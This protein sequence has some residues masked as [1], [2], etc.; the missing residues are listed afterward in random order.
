MTSLPPGFQA[1][2]LPEGFVVDQPPEPDHA[3]ANASLASNVA[4]LTESRG[5]KAMNKAAPIEAALTIGSGMVLGFPAYLGGGLGTLAARSMGIGDPDQD[6]QEVAKRYADAVTYHPFSEKGKRLAETLLSPLTLLNEKAEQAG[7]GVTDLT[8]SPTAGALTEATIQMLPA[9][10]IGALGRRLSGKTPTNE[11]IRDTAT[12]MTGTAETAPV[13]HVAAKLQAVYEKTGLDPEIVFQE[14]QSDPTILQ[15]LASSNIEV[16]KTFKDILSKKN[17]QETIL[18]DRLSNMTGEEIESEYQGIK[19]HNDIVERQAIGRFLG[20]DKLSEFDSLKT[21]RAQDRW[22]DENI[23]DEAQDFMNENM[24]PEAFAEQYRGAAGAF[25]ETSPQTLGASIAVLSKDI[26]KPGFLSSPSGT[27]FKAAL[28]YAH[29]R[30]WDM[31]EVLDAM[32]KRAVQWAGNDAK[33]LFSRIFKDATQTRARML[34]SPASEL[35]GVRADLANSAGF[36]EGPK[37]MDVEFTDTVPSKT[38]QAKALL[39]EGRRWYASGSAKDMLEQGKAGVA[40][41]KTPEAALGEAMPPPPPEKPAAA[42]AADEWR[43]EAE[44]TILS[45]IVQ[46]SE[47]FHVTLKNLFIDPRRTLSKLYTEGVDRLNPINIDEKSAGGRAKFEEGIGPYEAQRLTAGVFGKASLFLQ[48]GPRKFGDWTKK[49][50]PSIFDVLDYVKDDPRGFEAYIVSKHA[51][52]VEARGMKSGFD[53]EAAKQ[54]VADGAE[55]FEKPMQEWNKYGDAVLDYLKDAGLLSEGSVA[56]MRDAYKSHVPF[57]R[58]FEEQSRPLTGQPRNPIKKMK[59]SERDT[60]DP[61]VSKI[62]DTFLFL[63]LA[64]KNAARQKMVQLGPEFA[65]PVEMTARPEPTGG[66]LEKFMEDGD[67]E[68]APEQLSAFKPSS[69]QTG[70]DQIVVFENGIRKL[71]DVN[72]EVARAFNATDA[73]SASILASMLRASASLLRAG[74]TLAPEF[75]PRNMTRDA[76]SAF[77]YVGAH[78]IKTVKGAISLWTKDE[79]FQRWMAGGGANA[80]IV[81]MDRA[82]INKEIFSLNEKTGFMSGVWNT[83]KTPIE[84]LRIVSEFME[85]MTRLGSVRDELLQ[86]KTGAKIQALSLIGR[87]ATVDFAVHGADPFLQKWM[88]ATAF[89]N[90]AIQGV[91][92]MVMA[93]QKDPVGVNARAFAAITL[94]SLYLWWAQHDDFRYKD[95]ANW[96]RDLFWPIFH[97]HKTQEQWDAMAQNEKDAFL[98]ENRTDRI[99]KAFELGVLYGSMPERI[100]DAYIDHKPDAFKQFGSTLLNVFGFNIIPTVGIAPLEHMTNKSFFTN[101]ALIPDSMAKFLPEYQYTPYTTQTTRALG[102]IVGMLPNMHDSSFASPIVIDN[103]I[104]GW[105]GTLGTYAVQLA[106]VALRKT[107]VLPDPIRPAGTL[108]DIPGVKAFVIRYPSAQA[109]P[110]QDFYD[111]YAKS[112]KVITTIKHLASMGDAQAALREAQLDPGALVK[113]DGIHKGLANAQSMIQMVDKNQSIKPDEKRQLIDAAYMQMIQMATAGNAAVQ[114]IERSLKPRPIAMQAPAMVQ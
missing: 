25:D 29:E 97:G 38:E 85:N 103:Y 28:R 78:P 72:P 31:N 36:W 20:Q 7:H 80:A 30:G 109:Q 9:P 94:P 102:H 43:S 69:Y 96:E 53:L 87:E 51:I 14:A 33:E 70:R 21:K 74:V 112:E 60:L 104:R 105:S 77:V 71:Y 88:G 3:K 13:D 66:E 82:Y 58:S 114:V 81:S 26:D 45:K 56:A 50:A 17:E 18:A 32:R 62:K 73:G 98:R 11:S 12:A 40:A 84:A 16:P 44:K 22:L 99:P 15:D 63:A 5:E 19:S 47:P 34:S 24:K 86:A 10:F 27:T 79:A 107:G 52:E 46:E 101:R 64:E 76:V 68:K 89:M 35:G 2:S 111:N 1:D 91:R 65:R 49:V 6:P 92:T 113:L 55:K 41:G 4:A 83:A 110:I 37:P 100:L 108:A 8:G 106:D 48:Q 23:T 95:L 57:Y 93:M 42:A 75:S 54:V 67:V 59:G 39:D 90:P 61:I